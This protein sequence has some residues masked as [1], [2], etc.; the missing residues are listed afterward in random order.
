MSF[1]CHRFD[2]K[3]NEISVLASKKR[4]NEKVPDQIIFKLL[5]KN[6]VLF[7]LIELLFIGYDRNPKKNMFFGRNDDTKR[8]FRN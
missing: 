3:T 4:S 5:K 2:Q 7:V 1:W 8:T 6:E